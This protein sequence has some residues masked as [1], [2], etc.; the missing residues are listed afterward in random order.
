MLLLGAH[1]DQNLVDI[2][3]GTSI[4]ILLSGQVHR[5]SQ[6]SAFLLRVAD[7]PS[8]SSL[9]LED[10]FGDSDSFIDEIYDALVEMKYEV[11]VDPI[12]AK[13]AKRAIDAMLALPKTEKPLDFE[14]G[15]RAVEVELV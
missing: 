3:Y 10:P 7:R 5:S 4:Q 2:F 13:E 15:R 14:V 6:D 12:I 9:D 8:L 11:H 1:A